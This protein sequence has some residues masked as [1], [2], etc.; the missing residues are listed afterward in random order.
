MKHDSGRAAAVILF[1][2]TGF[3]V[4]LTAAPARALE[5]DQL[6]LI[7][8]SHAPESR[9]LAEFYAKQRKVPEG[10]ILGLELPFPREEMPIGIYDADVKPRVREFLRKYQP[11]MV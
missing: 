4:A 2:A 8:N 5:P 7:V 3:V 1:L 6:V 11:A 10:R 9:P